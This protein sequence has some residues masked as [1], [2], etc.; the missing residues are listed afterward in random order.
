MTCITWSYKLRIQGM[1]SLETFLLSDTIEMADESDYII[2]IFES[3][4]LQYIGWTGLLYSYQ[5]ANA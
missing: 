1:V 2:L 5:H 4:D 3:A